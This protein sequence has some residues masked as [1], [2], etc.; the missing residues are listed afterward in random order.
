MQGAVNQRDSSPTTRPLHAVNFFIK[1]CLIETF[2]REILQGLKKSVFHFIE[3]GILI[4]FFEGAVDGS[5]R[6]A[7]TH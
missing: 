2:N 3:N 7:P 1:V 4:N 5:L 6:V